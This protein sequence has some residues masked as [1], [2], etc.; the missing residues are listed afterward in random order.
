VKA[1]S[2][3]LKVSLFGNRFPLWWF[4]GREHSPELRQTRVFLPERFAFPLAPS[5]LHDVVSPLVLIRDH[6]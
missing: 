2:W 3:H 6:I 4:T 5:A 1:L